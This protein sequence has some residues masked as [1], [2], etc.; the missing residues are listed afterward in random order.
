M[1]QK[2]F[3]SYS[4]D[5]AAFVA[6]LNRY[7]ASDSIEVWSLV[8]VSPGESIQGVIAERIKSSSLLVA[9]FSSKSNSGFT[10]YEIASAIALGVRVL[11]V[12]L[13]ENVAVPITLEDRVAIHAGRVGGAAGVASAIKSALLSG[14]ENDFDLAV[15][16]STLKLRQDEIKLKL[17]KFEAE[18]A[19]RQ[20]RLKYRILQAVFYTMF[21]VIVVSAVL[22]LPDLF[23]HAYVPIVFGV[24][25]GVITNPL[26]SFLKSRILDKKSDTSK[27]VK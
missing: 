5:D 10:N 22:L 4:I 11:P 17:D 9:L 7:L 3:I 18:M 19:E 24:F 6:E 25:L 21:P 15:R 14:S 27:G 26:L 8:D 13:D 12:L 16:S 2:I 23:K 20:K 1:Y